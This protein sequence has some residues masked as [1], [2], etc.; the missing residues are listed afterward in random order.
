MSSYTERLLGAAKLDPRIYEEVEHDPQSMGQAAWTVV[1]ASFAAGIGSVS[2]G[3]VSGL[4]LGA[5]AALVGWLIWAYLTY[6]IGSKFLATSATEVSL[7]QML[8]TIG[9]ASS[10]GLIRILGIVPGLTGLVFLFAGL[11]M[12]AAMVVA[13][14]QALDYTSTMRSVTVCLLGWIVQALVLALF[15]SAFRP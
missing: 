3:G 4:L 2:A 12:L 5:V 10:P 8:R 14:R 9:F 13:V 6:Y 11:W 7:P 1:L 15:I